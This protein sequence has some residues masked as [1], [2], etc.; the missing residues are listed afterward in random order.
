M[1]LKE[2]EN[3]LECKNLTGDELLSRDIEYCYA[4]DMMSDVLKSCKIGSLLITGL[5]NQQVIQVAEIM[6]LKGIVFVSGKE[7][8]SDIIENAKE[9]NLPMLATEKHL[10][11][12]C[13]ILY[14]AGLR[15][16]DIFQKADDGTG[17]SI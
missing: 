5:V 17:N 1:I 13:G 10:F 12:A 16:K 9:K 14:S 11:E 2:I 15:G 7:P 8:S 4:T 3:V 6:D